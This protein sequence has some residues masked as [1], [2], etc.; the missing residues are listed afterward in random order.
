MSARGGVEGAAVA[1]TALLELVLVSTPVPETS[2]LVATV[3]VLN[4][5][6]LATRDMGISSE[7]DG[8]YISVAETSDVGIT[9]ADSSRGGPSAHGP[10]SSLSCIDLAA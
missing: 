10:T 3:S 6:E 1:I 5:A 7:G 4:S 8:G 2:T 9:V